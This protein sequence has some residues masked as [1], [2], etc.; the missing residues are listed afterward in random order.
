M[1]RPLSVFWTAV[2]TTAA[3]AVFSPSA[4][5]QSLH[6][7][8][9]IRQAV[10]PTGLASA[11]VGDTVRS[12]IRVVNVDDFG[13][14]VTVTSIVCV[15]HRGTGSVVTSNLLGAPVRLP[16]PPSSGFDACPGSCLTL[17]HEY[18]IQPDDG[19]VMTDHAEVGASDN[20]DAGGGLLLPLGFFSSFGSQIRVVRPCLQISARCANG[21][22]TATL[23]NC[24]NGPLADVV[25]SNLVNGAMA[26]VFGP[27]QLAIGQAAVI[28]VTNV[29]GGCAA[30]FF[31]SGTDELG[32]VVSSGAEV[33]C[34]DPGLVALTPKLV[35]KAF[36]LSFESQPGKFYTLQSISSLRAPA[37]NWQ[38]VLNFNGSGARLSWESDPSQAQAFYRVVMS[39]RAPRNEKRPL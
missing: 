25:V 23:E 35:G 3:M 15:L 36:H 5:A 29:C 34:S 27:A 11:H 16:P 7:A 22:A 39:D 37:T 4:W 20:F 21:N 6:G 32:L 38:T 18:Q 17:V 9:V 12:L 26:R 19:D 31:A 1:Q 10:G 28:S 24:G 30:A 33:T 13:D 14:S 2:F 8:L